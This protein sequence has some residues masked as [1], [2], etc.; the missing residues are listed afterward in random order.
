MTAMCDYAVTPGII[1]PTGSNGLEM[2]N[3]KFDYDDCINAVVFYC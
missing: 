1:L 3:F 2:I